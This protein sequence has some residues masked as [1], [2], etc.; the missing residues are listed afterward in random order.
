MTERVTDTT[1]EMSAEAP[2]ASPVVW[3]AADEFP[4]QPPAPEEEAATPA[5]IV[6]PV[7]LMVAGIIGW[8]SFTEFV[9]SVRQRAADA[10]LYAPAPVLVDDT[11]S[12]N[13][14][15]LIAQETNRMPTVALEMP[16]P[17]MQVAVVPAAAAPA[18][19][20]AVVPLAVSTPEPVGPVSVERR[21]DPGAA[22]TRKVS[23]L[24]R[25]ATF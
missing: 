11:L 6:W 9:I 7:A 10:G 23:P 15:E 24:F 18:A 17:E 12:S 13:Y 14:K 5:T 20:P 3:P 4:A 21:R 25:A 22:G 8:V 2:V 19:E 1:V 16:A